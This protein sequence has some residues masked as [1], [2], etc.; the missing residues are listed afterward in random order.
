MR[1]SCAAAQKNLLEFFDR[2]GM[3]PDETTR[4]YAEQ[5]PPENRAIYYVN[6][7]ARVYRMTSGA[8]ESVLGTNE[9]SDDRLHA[10][11]DAVTAELVAN[12]KNQVKIDLSY[13]NIPEAD[14]LGY[15]IIRCMY[16]GGDVIEEPVGFV[17]GSTGTFTDTI[18]TINNRII[19]YKVTLI[20]KYLYRSAEKILQPLKIEHDGSLD[21]S[22]WTVSTSG[23]TAVGDDDQAGNSNDLIY[24][25]EEPVT[26]EKEKLIDNQTETVYTA[27]ADATPEITLNFNKTLT[28]AGFKITG[29]PSVTYEIEARCNG[30]WQ[31]V[32]MGAFSGKASEIVYFSNEENKYVAT[33]EADAVKLILKAANGSSVSIAEL[34][35]LGV[36]GDN[37]DFRKTEDGSSDP[38]I[39]KLKE[40]YKYGDK[41]GDVIPKG[42]IVFAGSYKGNAAY[43]TV[44][45]FDQKGENVGKVSNVDGVVQVEANSIILADVPETGNIADVTNGTWIYWL[46]P[47]TDLKALGVTKVRAELYRVNK[48]ETNE[49]QRL[50]SDSLFVDV[51]ATLPEVTLDKNTGLQ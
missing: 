41:D 51:P 33:Y 5:F 28:V 32:A 34:D 31:N 15:E 19:Y 12:S 6:D 38:V 36:T 46:D 21:K 9:D 25:P 44:L 8:K 24:C 45:L 2:W 22:S 4:K 40:D 49:G 20:D 26:Y 47:E 43:N 35:V 10:V 18:A 11:S 27:K 17:L 16:S 7:E 29:G 14:V 3:T 48:A 23:L 50:V 37:V 1:L 30:I 13:K 39:G 42:S